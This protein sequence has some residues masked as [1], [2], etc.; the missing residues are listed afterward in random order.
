MGASSRHCCHPSFVHEINKTATQPADATIGFSEQTQQYEVVP[1][2]V[3][4]AIDMDATVKK[5]SMDVMNLPASI[6]LDD[7]CLVQAK[8]TQDEPSL[9]T[10][11]QNANRFI[12][13][14]IPLTL[15]G[16]QAG[17]GHPCPDLELDRAG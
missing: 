5:V 16:M 8:V 12:K 11:A 15:N 13:A 1:E 3:G 14:D 2:V 17:D 6:A 9:A 7:S 4:T 10:A